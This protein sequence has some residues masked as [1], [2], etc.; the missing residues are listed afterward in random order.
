MSKRIGGGERVVLA[1]SAIL[2]G[3][4]IVS[5]GYLANSPAGE[6][7]FD[8]AVAMAGRS[9]REFAGSAAVDCGSGST[10]DRVR[11]DSCV[12]AAF[13]AR[14]GFVA[15][16][17]EQGIDSAVGHTIAGN[18]SGVVQRFHFD[19]DPSGGGHTGP[20][21]YA[22]ACALPHLEEVGGSTRLACV[23][24]RNDAPMSEA[25]QRAVYK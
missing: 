17:R 21:V 11:L 9:G 15:L 1:V 16:L 20:R 25:S 2:V 3:A 6:S 10:R 19:S 18:A 13:M 12:V 23:G 24:D 4:A 5:L 14:R 7:D 8:G 22:E